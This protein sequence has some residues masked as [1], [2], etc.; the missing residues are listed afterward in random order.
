MRAV[1]AT[2]LTCLIVGGLGGFVLGHATGDDHN[3]SEAA[4]PGGFLQ[5]STF[6][7]APAPRPGAERP[8]PK[9]PAEPA[10]PSQG[11]E[12]TLTRARTQP[13]SPC[14]RSSCRQGFLPRWEV[15]MSDR[16]G[17]SEYAV[18]RRPLLHRTAWVLCGDHHQA[19]DLVQHVLTKLYLAWPRV[20]RMDSVDGYVRTMLVNA[21]LDRVRSGRELPRPRGVRPPPRRHSTTTPCSI[22]ARR[23]PGWRRGSVARSCCVT[24]G[25]CPSRRPLP[26][27]ASR[28]APSRARPRTPYAGSVICWNRSDEKGPCHMTDTEIHDLLERI[29]TPP[30][31]VADDVARGVSGSAPPPPVAD[32]RRVRSPWSRSQVPGSPS[33]ATPTGARGPPLLRPA[34]LRASRRRTPPKPTQQEFPTGPSHGPLAPPAT[35]PHLDQRE[36]SLPAPYRMVLADHLDPERRGAG[37]PQ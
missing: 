23:W 36:S 12:R 37:S 28:R 9:R 33:P 16:A 35:A 2:S 11:A 5:H 32:R 1:V 3:A 4:P 8:G 30:A 31:D 10:V 7:N 29:E 22:C 34:G 18:A 26:R 6:P 21:N 24:C 13:R 27:S 14:R 19:E 17:F 15:Q 20:S 25:V